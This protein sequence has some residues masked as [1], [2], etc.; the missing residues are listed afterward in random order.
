M[1]NPP[2]GR[3][4]EYDVVP[5]RRLKMCPDGS[6]STVGDYAGLLRSLKISL[7]TYEIIQ[8]LLN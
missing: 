1:K 5:M 6:V 2:R 8:Y 7:D 4:V 3:E